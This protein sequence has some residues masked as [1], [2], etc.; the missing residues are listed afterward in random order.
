MSQPDA[1]S[2]FL[3]ER[4]GVD[5]SDPRLLDDYERIVLE[6][7]DRE[8]RNYLTTG[9]MA[10]RIGIETAQVRPWSS[11][12]GITAHRLG[13]KLTFPAWQLSPDDAGRLAPLPH[14]TALAWAIPSDMREATWVMTTGQQELSVNGTPLTPAEWLAGGGDVTPVLDILAGSPPQADAASEG[15]AAHTGEVMSY[16]G[17]LWRMFRARGHRRVAW[18]EFGPGGRPDASA[19]VTPARMRV[20]DDAVSPFS[21]VFSRSRV[22]DPSAGSGWTLAGW[23]PTRPLTLVQADAI[24]DDDTDGTWAPSSVPG[25]PTIHLLPRSIDSF[26]D[27]PDFQRPLSNALPVVAAAA[28]RLGYGIRNY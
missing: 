19:A 21:A 28:A 7:R 15:A 27:A 22:I 24:T 11:S 5:D 18:N 10:E 9:E 26:P 25:T 20:G 4:G 6:T 1:E 12:N 13:P 3:R 8:G 2:L 23:M 16:E 14:L 17:P